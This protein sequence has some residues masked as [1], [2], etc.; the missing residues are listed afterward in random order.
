MHI[1]KPSAQLSKCKGSN[2]SCTI[3]YLGSQHEANKMERY[4]SLETITLFNSLGKIIEWKQIQS[5]PPHSIWGSVTEPISTMQR[6]TV[7]HPDFTKQ[8]FYTI[9]Y[10]VVKNQCIHTIDIVQS[11]WKAMQHP[12]RGVFGRC[13]GGWATKDRKT[14]SCFQRLRWFPIDVVPYGE[15][16]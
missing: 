9:L 15:V 6:L 11:C 16:M 14:T 1:V 4:Q 8:S 10:F 3:L 5:L 12:N 13:F 7:S 2:H